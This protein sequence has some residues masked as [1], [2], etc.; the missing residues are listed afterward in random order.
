VTQK[1]GKQLMFPLFWNVA[2]WSIPEEP[3]HNCTTTKA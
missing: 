1:E 2:P 3:R